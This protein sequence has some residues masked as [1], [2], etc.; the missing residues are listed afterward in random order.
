MSSKHAA[1]RGNKELLLF[2]LSLIDENV[3]D[4]ISLTTRLFPKYERT[5]VTRTLQYL[6]EQKYLQGSNNYT[7]T[8]RGRKTL[9]EE[10]VWSLS[11]PTQKKWDSKWRIVLFDIPKHKQKRRDIF[12]LRLK[13]LGLVLYQ[14]SVWVHPYPLEETVRAVSDFYLL[15]DC[16]H[17]IVAEKITGESALLKHFNLRR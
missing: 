10:R 2:I 1:A 14:N 13:E 6:R 16:V 7:L 12:R 4:R 8:F 17:F 15:S 3:K 11:I 9:S 5:R